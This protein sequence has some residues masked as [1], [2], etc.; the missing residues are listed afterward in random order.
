M[1]L[2]IQPPWPMPAETERIGKILL[3]END[4]YRLIG[5]RLFEQ[6]SEEEY[7]DL[8]SMEGKPGKSP[9][10]L[11]F[12]TVFQYIEKLSNR[13]AINSLR[14]R[15]DWKYALHLELE[16]EGFVF[17]VLSEFRDR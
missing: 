16:Y 2:K 8:Y 10:I 12:I 3:K 7:A 6:I 17:S 14:M 15:L 4:T 13:Q 5:D 11:A 1:C 9:V